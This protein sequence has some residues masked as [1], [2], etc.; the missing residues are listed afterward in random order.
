[1]ACGGS[2]S[3]S[4]KSLAFVVDRVVLGGFSFEYLSFAVTVI[5]PVLH[6]DS[7]YLPLMVHDVS[8]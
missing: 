8:N 7:L 3:M 2:G 4:E 5:P 6:N 1:M